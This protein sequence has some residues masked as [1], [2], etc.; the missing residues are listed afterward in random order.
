MNGGLQFQSTRPTWGATDDDANLGFRTLFQSTRPTWGA[1][2]IIQ[3]LQPRI[4]VSIHA[5]H[6]G[7]DESRHRRR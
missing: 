5:P 2:S 4:I 6:V 1:T 7:R 3:Q